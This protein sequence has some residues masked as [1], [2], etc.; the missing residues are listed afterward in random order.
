MAWAIFLL[1]PGNFWFYLTGTLMGLAASVPL[2]GRAEKILGQKDP[3]EIVLDE[4][5]AVP[6]CYA[7]LIGTLHF[8]STGLPSLRELAAQPAAWGWLAAGFLLFRLFDIWK[9]PPIGRI[10]NLPG[11]WGITADDV[12][13]ASFTG[14]FLQAAWFFL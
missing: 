5:T 11:G 12:L 7:S 14:L 1:A 4:I 13:A 8:S 2:C 3:G 6:A 10:Q 9:P